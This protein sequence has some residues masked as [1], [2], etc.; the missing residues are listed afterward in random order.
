MDFLGESVR[1]CKY[2]VREN[3][4]AKSTT[5]Y[6]SFFNEFNKKCKKVVRDEGSLDV[7]PIFNSFFLFHMRINVRM[8][9]TEN[10]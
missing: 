4:L 8:S 7:D 3:L 2:R 1:Y 10:T 5:Y 6:T 9:R